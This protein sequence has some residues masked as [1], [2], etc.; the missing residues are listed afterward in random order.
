[1]MMDD[2]L[3]AYISFLL[4]EKKFNGSTTKK[5]TMGILQNNIINGNV[6]VQTGFELPNRW[7]QGEHHNHY[8]TE[9][10]H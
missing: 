5:K 2:D 6:I 3:F 9:I 4:Q 8:T 10:R 1:M 7:L